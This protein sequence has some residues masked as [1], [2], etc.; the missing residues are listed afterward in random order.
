[1]SPT[2][3]LQQLQAVGKHKENT[4]LNKKDD[5]TPSPR[6]EE[7]ISEETNILKRQVHRRVLNS[8]REMV[9]KTKCR[10]ATDANVHQIRKMR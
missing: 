7:I 4:T 5:N 2:F 1:M 8:E 9:E 10:T 6:V 3:D